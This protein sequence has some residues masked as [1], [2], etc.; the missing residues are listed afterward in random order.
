[1]SVDQH[2][3]RTIYC[4]M[5]GHEVPFSYCRQGASSQPCRKIF[6]C[7]FQTFDIETFMKEHFSE[8]QIQTILTPPKPKM[9]SLIELIQK[10]QNQ[11]PE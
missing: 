2:D 4:R 5:L 9:A 8:Q 1:M 6:D 7:W 11:N 3:A 10:A